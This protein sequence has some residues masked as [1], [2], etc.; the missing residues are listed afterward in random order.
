MT[1]LKHVFTKKHHDLQSFYVIS[2]DFY[3][4]AYTPVIQLAEGRF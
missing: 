1:G 3:S 4:S 2:V